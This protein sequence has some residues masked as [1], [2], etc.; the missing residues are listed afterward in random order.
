MFAV[1]HTSRGP[2]ELELIL[3]K[4]PKS[5]NQWVCSASGDKSIFMLPVC[6]LE[7]QFAVTEVLAT[8]G[9]ASGEDRTSGR[10]HKLFETKSSR[11]R[12]DESSR[13]FWLHFYGSYLINRTVLPLSVGPK[14]LSNCTWRNWTWLLSFPPA[15]TLKTLS[16]DGSNLTFNCLW[17]LFKHSVSWWMVP[18][19]KS[20]TVGMINGC[21]Y[22]K[23]TEW[24][25]PES[26]SWGAKPSHKVRLI[27]VAN[28]TSVR[29]E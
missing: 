26:K 24:P 17:Q 1:C 20:A 23:P 28:E 22:C 4:S 8:A 7:K 29:V 21:S 6:S 3:F 18:R 27:L 25:V 16:K 11:F 12:G 2:A 10:P 5:P 19:C 9:A 15:S 14:P 13:T